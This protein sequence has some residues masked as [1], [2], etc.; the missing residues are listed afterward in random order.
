[1]DEKLICALLFGEAATEKEAVQI[2][3]SY[4]GCPYVHLMTTRINHLFATFFLPEKQRWWIKEIEKKPKATLGL[5]KAKVTIVDQVQW[6]KQPAMRLSEKP[7][8][9]SPCGADCGRC[10][11]HDRCLCCPSTTFYKAHGRILGGLKC[12]R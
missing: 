3:E 2:A 7:Q 4:R 11:T 9:I 12:H 8:E 6:P 5:E 10:P 1:M